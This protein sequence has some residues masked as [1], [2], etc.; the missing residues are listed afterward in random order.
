MIHDLQQQQ[1]Q[2]RRRRQQADITLLIRCI[3][4]VNSRASTLA[5]MF[6]LRRR[7]VCDLLCHLLVLFRNCTSVFFFAKLQLNIGTSLNHNRLAQLPKLTAGRCCEITKT[8]RTVFISVSDAF[9]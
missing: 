4:A 6:Q 7:R 3:D 9:L 5:I 8:S 2:R 1:Q